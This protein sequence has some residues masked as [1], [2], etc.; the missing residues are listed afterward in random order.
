MLIFFLEN[1]SKLSNI[2]LAMTLII[3]L[4]LFFNLILNKSFKF[5]KKFLFL[6][7]IFHI[8]LS[9]YFLFQLPFSQNNYNPLKIL[10]LLAVF[11]SS[12]SAGYLIGIKFGKK[13]IE[14]LIASL[15]FALI[16]SLIFGIM[17]DY[18]NLLELSLIGLFTAFLGSIG[19]LIE[20]KFKRQSGLKDSGKILKS[21]GGIYDRLDSLIFSAPFLYLMYSFNFLNF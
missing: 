13:T 18:D 6:I 9:L 15:F 14:G 10:F 16:I 8:I 5:K 17:T 1:E 3:N 2:L 4:Y 19:D 20:S 21:H 7:L 12:D 11:W